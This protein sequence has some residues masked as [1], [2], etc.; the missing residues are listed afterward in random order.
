MSTIFTSFNFWKEVETL[1]DENVDL[2]VDENV[3]EK[4]SFYNNISATGSHQV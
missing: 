3:D 4:L 1:G 2:N